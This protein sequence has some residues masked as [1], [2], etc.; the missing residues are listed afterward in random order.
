MKIK[1]T[2]E[3]IV[4][5]STYKVGMNTLYRQDHIGEK[6]LKLNLEMMKEWTEEELEEIF[7]EN[8]NLK[9]FN[10]KGS[11]PKGS[12]N[13]KNLSDHMNVHTGAKPYKCDLCDYACA[14]A[15]NLFNHKKHKHQ[16]IS[17]KQ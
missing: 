6:N 7:D 14:A 8:G 3:K 2:M 16:N 1:I 11:Y 15:T 17:S 10:R 13:M 5:N 12:K 4:D 9:N